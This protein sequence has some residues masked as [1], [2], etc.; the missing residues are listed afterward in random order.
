MIL[1]EVN[2]I[3]SVYLKLFMNLERFLS[4]IPSSILWIRKGPL[5]RCYKVLGVRF[6]SLEGRRN[7]NRLYPDRRTIVH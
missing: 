3:R 2:K 6:G 1:L 5:Y 7:Q 4:R